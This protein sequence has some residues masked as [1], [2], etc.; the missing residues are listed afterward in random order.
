MYLIEI[1]CNK[2]E[3]KTYR[4]QRNKT[5]TPYKLFYFAFYKDA[6]IS[7][8][9]KCKCVSTTRIVLV[10]I[11]NV[12][13]ITAG[14]GRWCFLYIHLR[15][16]S[17][18]A[19]PGL[20]RRYP[21]D[22]GARAECEA[23]TGGCELRPATPPVRSQACNQ[24]LACSTFESHQQNHIFFG[25]EFIAMAATEELSDIL[26]RRQEINDKLEEGLEIKPK[27]KFVNVYT[28]FHEF[29]RKEIKQY[30]QTFNK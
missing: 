19:D 23:L 29:S 11:R 13:T 28:E 30:E 10:L 24:P 16:S 22:Y 6:N 2:I 25:A 8:F 1:F 20:R 14:F 12:K 27:Y 26:S 5:Y 4:N 7:N 9:P 18:P 3:F 21:L 17:S 15:R